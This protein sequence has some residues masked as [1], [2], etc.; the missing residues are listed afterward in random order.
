MDVRTIFFA[1][2]VTCITGVVAMVIVW[3]ANR[4]VPGIREWAAAA[5][6]AGV[7]M[8]LFTLQGLVPYRW[9]THVLPTLL[10]QGMMILFFLGACRFSDQPV[11][12]RRLVAKSGVVSLAYLYFLY[13]DDSLAWRVRLTTAW[14]GCIFLLT[15]WA[16]W[17]EKR[18]GLQ[19]SARMTMGVSLVAVAILIYR[20]LSWSD[21]PPSEW[22]TGNG[23]ESAMMGMAGIVMTFLWMFCALFMVNQYQTR[24]VALGLQARHAAEQE[25]LEARHE[26]ERQRTLRMRQEMA[27]ELHDGIGGITA[28]VAMLAGMGKEEGGAKERELLH[29]IEEMA[30][31]GSREVRDLMGSVESGVFRAREWLADMEQY[32]RK[33]AGAAGIAVEWKVEGT[34]SDEAIRDGAA[35]GSLMRTVMEAVHNLV[36]HAAASSAEVRFVFAEERLDVSVH[37]DGRGFT[38]EREGGRGVRNMRGRVEELGGTFSI[39]GGR[40]TKLAISVPL[41]LKVRGKT[42]P[43]VEEVA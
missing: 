27:R 31:E 7:A 17:R 23:W 42:L 6:C 10:H 15:A 8:P 5:V 36:L 25:L 32:A 19:F 3:L 26:I 21:T 28:T 12:V 34:V 16:L 2:A 20:L 40:G 33:A 24:E 18:K 35:A 30:L 4:K 22:I 13:G 37:D 39:E 9:L 11:R 14:S 38:R 41:P 1:V 43:Q 29:R